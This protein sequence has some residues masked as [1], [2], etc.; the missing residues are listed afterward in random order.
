M[1]TLES[2]AFIGN[3]RYLSHTFKQSK[4]L[5]YCK[6]DTVL[7]LLLVIFHNGTEYEYSGVDSTTY[8]EL[9]SAPSAG[10]YFSK[11]LRKYKFVRLK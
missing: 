3:N 8:E 4:T 6:Y 9:I 10:S 11:I 7:S 1:E 2:K 5:A